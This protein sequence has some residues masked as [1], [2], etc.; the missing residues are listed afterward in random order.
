MSKTYDRLK[1]SEKIGRASTKARFADPAHSRI[2]EALTKGQ[3]EQ[4]EK[5]L[6]EQC[7]ARK[8]AIRVK[9]RCPQC[10]GEISLRFRI[11]SAS[12]ERDAHGGKITPP[13]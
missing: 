8:P 11:K 2:W 12:N 5:K 13:Q 1:E 4:I 3:R 9:V 6:L 10:G 7:L